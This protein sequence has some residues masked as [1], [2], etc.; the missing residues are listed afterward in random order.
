MRRS[1]PN[2]SA[3]VSSAA[4]PINL[5]LD[6]EK[7]IVE[8]A[9]NSALAPQAGLLGTLQ[10]PGRFAVFAPINSA[11]KPEHKDTLV[12]VPTCHVVAGTFSGTDLKKQIRMG[13]GKAML[14]TVAGGSLRAMMDGNIIV[15]KDE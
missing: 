4:S 11:L 12:K 3:R 14:K 7:S 6:P 9:A 8:I 1:A 2:G 15:L 10:S 13:G 5:V